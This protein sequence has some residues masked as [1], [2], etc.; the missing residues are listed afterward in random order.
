MSLYKYIN[1]SYIAHN[2]WIAYNSY[3]S[4]Y[5]PGNY[6]HLRLHSNSPFS[7]VQIDAGCLQINLIRAKTA[8]LLANEGDQTYDTNI[9]LTAGV[10]G[11]TYGVQGIMNLTITTNDEAELIKSELCSAGLL[12]LNNDFIKYDGKC[13]FM[14]GGCSEVINQLLT[15]RE[16]FQRVRQRSAR[17]MCECRKNVI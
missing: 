16:C 4:R 12:E 5:H 2:I 1:L 3:G 11:Q 8:A 7:Y 14:T 9:F 17:E 10:G 13:Q 15:Y 6:Q